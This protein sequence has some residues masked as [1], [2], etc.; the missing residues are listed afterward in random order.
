MADSSIQITA[1]SG[2]HVDTRTESTNSHHR[3]VIVIGDPA[4]NDGVAPVDGT[5][6]LKVDLGAD[7][8]VTVT[9]TVDLGSVDN[10]VLDSIA[11]L[12]GTIDADT[13]ALAAAEAGSGLSVAGAAADD[14]AASGNPFQMGGVY[15]SGSDTVDA[16]DVGYLRMSAERELV[17]RIGDGAGGVLGAATVTEDDSASGTESIFLAGGERRDAPTSGVTSDGDFMY[18]GYSASGRL[19]AD[20]G[21]TF[22]KRTT[23]TVTAGGYTADDCLG[24]EQSITGMARVSGEGGVITHVA[25][26][27]EDDDADGWAAEDVEILFF[28]SDPGGT[29]TDNAV[30]AGTGLTDADAALLLGTVLLD[31]K[32]DLGNVTMLKASSVNLPYFCSGGTTL[33]AVAVNRGGATPE[34]TDAINF[35]YGGVFD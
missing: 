6:G 23:P 33:Y 4:D 10:A 32:V 28:Q 30:L 9:G 31:T 29:Y 24:G 19:W 25:M 11:A 8:D 1:G 7:N 5:A 15:Y 21:K 12:L 14:A 3:Q 16:G 35:V 34:A 22:V 18:N 26:I 17:V 20:G 27:A 13:S 2:T